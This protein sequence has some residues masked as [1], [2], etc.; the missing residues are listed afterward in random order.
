MKVTINIIEGPDKGKIIKIVKPNIFIVGRS[1]NAQIKLGIP[2]TDPGISRMHFKL[3][4]QSEK[5]IIKDLNS[6]NGTYL[7]GKLI[8]KADLKDGD[9][10]TIG[11]STLKINIEKNKI[12]GNNITSKFLFAC[13]KCGVDLTEMVNIDGKAYE[14]KKA[15]YICKK[16]IIYNSDKGLDFNITGEYSM[17]GIL[18]RD[19]KVCRIIPL[20]K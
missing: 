5:S 7:N 4:I 19:L 16:C 2:N 20:E 1:D 12:N 13:N 3:D 10:I 6:R 11:A 18:G 8:K 14:F 17:I 15:V 9:K